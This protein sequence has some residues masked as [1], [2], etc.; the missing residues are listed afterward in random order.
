MIFQTNT[1]PISQCQHFAIIHDCL[2]IFNVHWIQIAIETYISAL[3]KNNHTHFMLWHRAAYATEP[4]IY[5]YTYTWWNVYSQVHMLVLPWKFMSTGKLKIWY[6]SQANRRYKRNSELFLCCA[7]FWHITGQKQQPTLKLSLLTFC[8]GQDFKYAHSNNKHFNSLN[9]LNN[10]NEKVKVQ[11]AISIQ[12]ETKES[13]I[14]LDRKLQWKC[15]KLNKQKIVSPC[16][17]QSLQITH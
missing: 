1:L 3:L 6:N 12:I 10:A 14:K 13:K 15:F 7:F 9:R 11:N 16:N 5:G 2:Q 4:N 17:R 8:I